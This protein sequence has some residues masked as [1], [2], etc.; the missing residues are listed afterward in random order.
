MHERSPTPWTKRRIAAWAAGVLL[1]ALVTGIA[2]ERHR[3]ERLV[4]ASRMFG[5]GDQVGNFRRLRE[6]FPGHLIARSPR[7]YSLPVGMPLALPA[8]FD[9]AGHSESTDDFL[10][11]T[12][13]TGLLILKNDRLIYEHYWRGNDARTPWIAWS[14]SKSFTEAL[15]GIAVQERKVASIE[16]PVTRY[17]PELRGSAYDGVRIKDVLQMSSGARWN[18]DYGDWNSDVNRFGRTFALGGS[19]D[20]YA[21]SLRRE[22]APG[23][24]NRYHTMDSQVLGMILRRVTGQ[25]EA[26]YLQAK[27]WWPL[28][29]EH[30]AWWITDE[31]GTEFAAGGLNATLRDVAKLG[32]LYLH[33]GR[34]GGTQI[35]PAEWVRASVT[36]DAPHLMPGKRASSDAV[37]GYGMQWW[38]P[39]MSGAFMAVGIYNQFI[40]VNPG[41]RLI[42]AKTSA[43]HRYG[44]PDSEENDR[45]DEHVAFFKAIEK[46]V[47]RIS[48]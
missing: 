43:N 9:N 19:L 40:Y 6:L 33:E 13:T 22:F 12:D 14:I 30:D 24:F 36:P 41:L 18:E 11:A 26:E 7:P 39:D 27:L 10:A 17:V 25:S 4:F 3:I 5:G 38:V 35:V 45:E 23:T 1:L 16:D 46:A 28:G 32:L 47:Q 8:E 42:V 44:N 20:G 31:A 2:L 15:F 34:W 48:D 29:M 21:A 37:W